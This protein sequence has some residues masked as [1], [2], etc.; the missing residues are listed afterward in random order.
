MEISNTENWLK[1]KQRCIGGSEVPAILNKDPIR[2]R[3]D[4]FNSKIYGYS[5][6]EN[7]RMTAGKIL[8]KFT[9]Q[10]YANFNNLKFLNYYIPNESGVYC[11]K[12]ELILH[13]IMY[14]FGASIDYM[15]RDDGVLEC[16]DISYEPEEVIEKHYIQGQWY[17]GVTGR[18]QLVVAYN[19]IP[20]S[21]DYDLF[22]SKQWS[23]IGVLECIFKYKEFESFRD[24]D[25]IELA[26]QEV[27][28]FWTDHIIPCIPPEPSNLN[29]IKSL[30]SKSINNKI[31]ELNT[32]SVELWK[33]LITAKSNINT[34]QN[35]YDNLFVQFINIIKD[36]EI[37]QYEGKSV[38]TYKPNKNGNRI[39]RFKE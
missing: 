29:D 28:K 16:K 22:I 23:E 9:A 26:Q 5:T 31:Y 17:L 7:N 19:I 6:F 39:P 36:A 15:I 14:Y 21:F 10:R 2:S 37:V 3:L 4:V 30:Y 8:E 35:K 25:L 38:F 27:I 13:R 12:H 1:E 24:D 34:F 32:D 33:K 20:Q 11:P 18:Q